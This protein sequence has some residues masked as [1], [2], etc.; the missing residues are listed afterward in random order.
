MRK[1]L[2]NMEQWRWMPDDLGD[3]Y[4]WVNI[5]E[6]MMR[7]VKDG[8]VIHA[9]RVIVGKTDTQ[10]PVFSD[11][12][13]QVIFHPFWGVPDSIKKNE[14]QPSLARGGTRCSSATTC[15]SSTAAATSIRSA[16]DWAS[17]DMRNFHVYQPPGGE[18]R[19]GRRQVPLPQQARRLHARH[20][21]PRTCSTP[22]C[23]P[24][25]TAACACATR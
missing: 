21:A 1:L 11:E 18:Q 12:M 10:T 7:V 6:F 5:P 24:S 17:A 20:A 4:V 19:A 22:R 23:A 3:F 8:K 25:A 15:A 9:E 2:V 14:I 16:V 13:E